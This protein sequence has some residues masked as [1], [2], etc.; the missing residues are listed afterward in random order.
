MSVA[1]P[2]PRRRYLYVPRPFVCVELSLEDAISTV[3]GKLKKCNY[4]RLLCAPSDRVQAKTNK[5]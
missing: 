2:L 5:F 4:N 1:S 3:D